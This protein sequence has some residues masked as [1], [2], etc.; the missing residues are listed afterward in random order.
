M[1][2][3]AALILLFVSGVFSANILYLNTIAS[4]SH[5]LWNKK[6][7]KGLADKGHNITMVSV[8][9]DEKPP[10]NVHYIFIEGVYETLY[11]DQDN[12][13][14]EMAEES[15][16]PSVL[17]ISNWCETC[18]DGVLKSKG[19][20]TILNYPNSFKFDIVI[21]DFTCG[22]CLLPLLHKFNY[23]P[24]V[25]VTAFS[26]PPYSHH[27]TGGQKFPAIVPHYVID[28]SQLMSYPQRLFNA[29]LYL[30]DSM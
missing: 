14:M 7:I 25:S 21:Q 11:G 22:P 12:M 18:C 27:L 8:D 5:H 24:M 30:V 28:Y 17:S 2:C 29:F 3:F 19:L 13:L 16:V 23:P 6:L 9:N 1:I 4:P 15:I 20:D 10:P 26:N